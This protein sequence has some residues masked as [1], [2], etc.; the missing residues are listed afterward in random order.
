MLITK[1]DFLTY[2]DAPC[3]LWAFKHDLVPT[4][5]RNAYLD[6][7]SAQGYEVEKWALKYLADCLI[8]AYGAMPE[9]IL[10]QQTVTTDHFEARADILIRQHGS[11]VW[12]IY[13]IKSSTEVKKE[14][15]YDVTFQALVLEEQYKIGRAFVMH[16]NRDYIRIG[17]VDCKQLFHVED[18]SSTVNE[19][20]EEVGDLRD[21]A[22]YVAGQDSC[23]RLTGCWK[24][25]ECPCPD[26]CHIDLPEYSIFDINNFTRSKKKVELLLA[27]GVRSIH[28]VPPEFA[29]SD[30]QRLQVTVAQ[31][32][33]PVID[34]QTI[35][36]EL[37][38]LVYPLC[39]I[40]YETFNPAVPMYDRYGPF[41]HIPF[42]YSLH[43]QREPNGGIEH[44][45]FLHLD[46]TDPI[47]DFLRLL[48]EQLGNNGSILVWNKTFE[49]GRNKDMGEMYP[50]F[51]EFC[52]NM[53]SRHYDLALIF[54]KQWY[55]HPDFKGSYSIKKV[56]PVLVPE[57]SYKEMEVG[58]GATAMG[59]W[60]RLVSEENMEH[61]EKTR[62]REAMLRYCEMDT[63]AMVK[64]WQ[65]LQGLSS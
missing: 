62:L 42:Q 10:I 41:T 61:L 6:H 21:D 4:Q 11:D 60:K 65:H 49:G 16:L 54:Q 24:P 22:L 8:P 47:P 18:V 14:H 19:M 7:L 15:Y 56:L 53:N 28:D 48:Q 20:K 34:L 51:A 30:A 12:D 57:L 64:I 50:E 45:E 58:E 29:L 17:D 43:I 59:T 3:H 38:A 39:F 25:K 52:A 36:S 35:K 63:F 46:K 32:G 2:L 26:I 44:Y 55:A 13:E 5:E 9:D 37:Q 1:S 23:E 40:D 31:S 27:D 33:N